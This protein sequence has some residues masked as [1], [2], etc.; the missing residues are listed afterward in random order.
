MTAFGMIVICFMGGFVAKLGCEIF[1]NFL[2][3]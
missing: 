3:N 1:S 2:P